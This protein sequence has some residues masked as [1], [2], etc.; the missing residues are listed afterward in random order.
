MAL[1]I[2]IPCPNDVW[3]LVKNL[4]K[5]SFQKNLSV[6]VRLNLKNQSMLGHQKNPAGTIIYRI[7]NKNY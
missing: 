2:D 6:K 4:K 7:E 5:L 1:G 3:F